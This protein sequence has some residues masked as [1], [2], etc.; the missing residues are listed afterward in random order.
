MTVAQ[1]IAHLQQFNPHATVVQS[2]RAGTYS[3]TDFLEVGLYE[4]ATETAGSFWVPVDERPWMPEPGVD[5][6]A[7]CLWAKSWPRGED[8]ETGA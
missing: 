4:A 5:M 1:L 8:D 6:H 3:P 7:V 2:E